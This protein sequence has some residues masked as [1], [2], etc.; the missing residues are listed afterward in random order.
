MN[1]KYT[2][3][4]LPIMIILISIVGLGIRGNM[5]THDLIQYFINI[6]LVISISINIKIRDELRMTKGELYPEAKK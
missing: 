5:T 1:Y 3:Y 6:L 4:I 2:K